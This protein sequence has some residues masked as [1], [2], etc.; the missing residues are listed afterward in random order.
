MN[1]KKVIIIADVGSNFNGKK[2]M[3]K[4]YIKICKELNTDIVKFQ[5]YTADTLLSKSHPAYKEMSQNLWGLP[6]EWHK[7]LKT[8]ADSTGI[9]FMSTPF[10]PE[11]VEILEKIGVRRYKIASGD[12]TY[13]PLLERIA[14]TGKPVIISTGMSSLGDIERAINI[15]KSGGCTDITLLHCV[16]SY[17]PTYS[18]M[19]LLAIK[20]LAEAFKLP[21]G[22]S[23][24]SPGFSMDLAAISLGATIIEKHITIDKNMNTPDAS[25]ALNIDEFKNMV[26]EIRHLESALGNGIK[27]PTINERKNIYWTR[28]GIYAKKDIKAGSYIKLEDLA[29]LRPQGT[30]PAEMYRHITGK[31]AKKDISK[32]EP[33]KWEHI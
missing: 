2:Q 17:P 4:A 32:G 14:K 3:A 8:Y 27:K 12:I 29:F 21:V 5:S 33:I 10:S 23:D 26:T 31:K 9:E 13:I 1:T 16:S 25:F 22:F 19:N 30:I 18:E 7:E 15:F 6:I 11:H 20:T 24:H 28:R